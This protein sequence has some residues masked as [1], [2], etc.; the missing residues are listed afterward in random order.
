MSHDLQQF[1]PEVR[2]KIESL[3]NELGQM[4]RRVALKQGATSFNCLSAC[5]IAQISKRDRRE[6]VS[7]GYRIENAIRA[8]MG[9][10]PSE[11]DNPAA[12][13]ASAAAASAIP[14][15]A[16]AASQSPVV[17]EPQT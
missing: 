10:P 3:R 14:A 5:Q 1:E 12:P 2:V 17:S 6:L 15:A 7:E 8:L 4:F 16:A 9:L 11:S 13:P